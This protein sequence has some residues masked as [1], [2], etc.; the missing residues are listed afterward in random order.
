IAFLR[1]GVGCTRPAR[2]HANPPHAFALLRARRERQRRR[3]APE[4]RYEC[5]ASDH[6]ITSS[7]RVTSVGGRS[8]PSALAVLRLI[9]SS[10]LVGD[11]IGKSPALAPFR[12]RST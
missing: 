11:S 7:A 1:I 4:Q 10:I 5:A 2:E 6:S 12:I 8:R 9:V 3:R